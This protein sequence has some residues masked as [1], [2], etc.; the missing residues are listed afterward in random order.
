MKRHK[1][2][3]LAGP[4]N[5]LTRSFARLKR[6]AFL[7]QT[8]S[9]LK[10]PAAQ[11]PPLHQVKAALALHPLSPLKPLAPLQPLR[12]LSGPSGSPA[13]PQAQGD[14]QE[15]PDNQ[16]MPTPEAQQPDEE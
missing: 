6:T 8:A 4:A 15:Q 2:G 16:E 12:P 9:L 10:N 14:P 5:Y 1:S 11:L 13:N 7:K 3:G